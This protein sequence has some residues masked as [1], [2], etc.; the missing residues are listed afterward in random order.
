MAQMREFNK[1]LYW[2]WLHLVPFGGMLR[3]LQ[4]TSVTSVVLS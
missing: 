2:N 3:E 1:T 4:R